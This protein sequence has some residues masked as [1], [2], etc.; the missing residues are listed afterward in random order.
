MSI[1]FFGLVLAALGM[2]NLV[3]IIFAPFILG[4]GATGRLHSPAATA[5]IEADEGE[6]VSIDTPTYPQND[7]PSLLHE[8]L[9]LPR[10]LCQNT[11]TTIEVLQFI[12][13]FIS[14]WEE[15]LS[16]ANT[17]DNHVR[18]L[19]QEYQHKNDGKINSGGADAISSGDNDVGMEIVEKYEK[20]NPAHGDKTFHT[21]LTRIQQ[22]PGQILRYKGQ[23][24]AKT[25]LTLRFFF[26]RYNREGNPLL[27][28]PFHDYPRRCSYCQGEMVFE[29]Q[30]LSTLIPKLRLPVDGKE[31]ARLEYGTVLIYTCRQS[32]WSSNSAAQQEIVVVQAE[33]C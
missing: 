20:S 16:H 27:M 22:N 2:F 13:Y 8:A 26:L 19:L 28:Y 9:P 1:K 12:P 33:M 3:H 11:R 24:I 18:E 10:E 7:I 15:S 23:I 17:M 5:E 29:F 14:V 21:F 30:I 25:R 4:G 32:C 31:G 6:I